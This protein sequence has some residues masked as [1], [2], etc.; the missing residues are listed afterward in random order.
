MYYMCY[1]K[2]YT[3]YKSIGA[4]GVKICERWLDVGNFINDVKEKKRGMRFTRIDK[5]KDY[6]PDNWEWVTPSEKR[7]R[8]KNPTRT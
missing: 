8:S 6:G 1:N 7:I 3:G 4:L 5:N 2:T